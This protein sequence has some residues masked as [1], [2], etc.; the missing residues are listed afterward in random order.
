MYKRIIPGT[1]LK[2]VPGNCF[3]DQKNGYSVSFLI[4]LFG[5]KYCNFVLNM[6]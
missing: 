3:A 1:F 2:A 5:N 4:H 6:L